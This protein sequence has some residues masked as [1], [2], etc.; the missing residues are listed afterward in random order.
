MD[1]QCLTSQ[2]C[3]S[4]FDWLVKHYTS[5][6][7]WLVKHYT[8]I[9]DWLV[10]HC[11]STFDW[12]VKHCT[13]TFDSRKLYTFDRLFEHCTSSYDR[14]VKHMLCPSSASPSL[15]LFSECVYYVLKSLFFFVSLASTWYGVQA[16]FGRQQIFTFRRLGCLNASSYPDWDC[17]QGTTAQ[18]LKLRAATDAFM[19]FMVDTSFAQCLTHCFSIIV[20]LMNNEYN[21]VPYRAWL[22]EMFCALGWKITT[23]Q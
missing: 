9:F 23:L 2:Y 12:L 8:S 11:T 17:L 22:L 6:F 5:T 19:N 16:S 3:T 21:Y 18:L 4:T 14:L 20:G 7:D 1:V 13:S 10:K 15:T